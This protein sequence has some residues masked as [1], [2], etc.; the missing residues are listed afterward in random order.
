M[1][2]L[3][4]LRGMCASSNPAYITANRILLAEDWESDEEWVC[5]EE[6]ISGRRVNEHRR[7]SSENAC[8]YLA[9]EGKED[10]SLFFRVETLSGLSNWEFHQYDDDFFPS[11]PHGH[12]NGKSQPKL[13]PYLGWVYKG[14][15]QLR[16]ES[17]KS[18]IYLWNDARFREFA[19]NAIGYYLAHHSNYN[20][21]RVPNPMRLPRRR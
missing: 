17:K 20:G 12:W 6:S 4:A 9:S 5:E 7:P 13:D 15:K 11:I 14:S 2:R 18:I 10:L 1:D 16:R 19:R 3:V 21:W 8:D